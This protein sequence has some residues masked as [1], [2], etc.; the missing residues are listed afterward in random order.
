MATLYVIVEGARTEPILY[1]A[2]LPLL[3]PDHREIRRIE[4][5]AAATYFIIAGHGYP[6]YKDRIK[7]AIA[8]MHTLQSPF[9]HLLVC[10]DSEEWARPAREA[11]LDRVIQEA[12]CPVPAR[13]I[14]ADCCIETW[15]LGHRK[16]VRPAPHSAELR[17]LQG[18][19]NVRDR[20]PERMPNLGPSTRAR[21][22]LHYLREVFREHELAYTKDR[23][24]P[25][26]DANYF[27]QLRAR[28]ACQTDG[29]PDLTSFATLLDLPRWLAEPPTPP[30]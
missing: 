18:L 5:A 13:T 6:H 3:L 16:I 2:W 20:D 10:V 14:V 28:T 4:D 25:A 30:A 21:S 24:G 8:D 11:E 23:P 1:R 17:R 29:L 19:Y 9:T 22:H 12:N 26:K 7:A 27:E 15:L